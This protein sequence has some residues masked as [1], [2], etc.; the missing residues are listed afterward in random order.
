MVEKWTITADNL[1]QQL[2]GTTEKLD[3]V[4][5]WYSKDVLKMSKESQR[6]QELVSSKLRVVN[7]AYFLA[8]V[9]ETIHS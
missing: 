3:C 4:L 2:I 7:E 1:H 5:S 6:N 8:Y 9:N